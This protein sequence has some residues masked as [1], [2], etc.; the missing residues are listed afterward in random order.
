MIARLLLAFAAALALA[1]P[2]GAQVRVAVGP[3]EGSA[4]DATERAIERELEGRGLEIVEGSSEA[5]ARVE[6]R[7]AFR[8]SRRRRTARVRLEVRAASGE[9]RTVQMRVRA[10][11]LARVGR[12]V[13][14]EVEALAPAPEELAPVVAA[15]AAPR[16]TPRPAP[17]PRE[18][19]A[20]R[21]PVQ[22]LVQVG[23]GVRS[24]AVQLLAPDGLDAAYR[25]EPYFELTA[26][27]EA[28]FFDIAFVR[29]LFGSSAGLSSEREDPSLGTL[30]SWFA[31]MR[32]D[33]GASV[34]LGETVELG[35]AVGA[36]WDRYELA[37]NELV[38]T[39]EYVH[40]RIAA[41]TSIR[42]IRELLV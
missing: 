4:G 1:A 19:Q 30:E 22:V 14:S 42:L 40:L 38:P 35:G 25:A 12:R 16:A 3:F 9:V 21:A 15:P 31:W 10:R 18:P 7:A 6:G 34:L 20:E 17:A 26:R 23:A 28:R 36:G 11:Q 29:A 27:A 2:A 33:A 8:G 13:A 41:L 24:R 5:D 37:Y 32:A 39:T